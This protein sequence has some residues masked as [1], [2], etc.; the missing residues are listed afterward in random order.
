MRGRLVRP[1]RRPSFPLVTS[2]NP[3]GLTIHLAEIATVTRRIKECANKFVDIFFIF[4]FPVNHCTSPPIPDESTHMK[5]FGW[6]G[7]PVPVGEVKFDGFKGGLLIFFFT[8]G[9]VFLPDHHSSLNMFAGTGCTF[10]TR[11]STPRR[12]SRGFVWPITNS[13]TSP[14]K[15]A[16]EVRKL[17]IRNLPQS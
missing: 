12:R 5:I 11:A 16:R 4:F 14:L 1:R 6:T 10:R 3:V 13:R 8:N 2:A 7:K 15:L 9:F 17:M